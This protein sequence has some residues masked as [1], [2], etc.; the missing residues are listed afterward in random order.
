MQPVQTPE[1]FRGRYEV[2]HL[3][4]FDNELGHQYGYILLSDA[5]RSRLGIQAVVDAQAGVISQDDVEPRGKVGIGL[6]K[7]Y[8]SGAIRTPEIV[9]L[10]D[11]TFFDKHDVAEDFPGDSPFDSI[12]LE[13]IEYEFERQSSQRKIYNLF[14]YPRW[15]RMAIVH[16][17]GSLYGF[18]NTLRDTEVLRERIERGTKNW[19]LSAKAPS[20]RYLDALRIMAREF[21]DHVPIL[22]EE[23]RYLSSFF[24]SGEQAQ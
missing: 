13:D 7:G 17:I 19:G 9:K 3:W 20:E 11:L 14:D 2:D 5:Y 23:C 12:D 15:Q 1:Q 16:G 21:I 10:E 22:S 4:V 24:V 18:E 8:S 6:K